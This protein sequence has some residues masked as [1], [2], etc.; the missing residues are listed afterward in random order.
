MVRI[1]VNGFGDIA[2][3]LIG[4]GEDDAEI[5]ITHINT[6]K[7]V[8]QI[9]DLLQEA[10]P[11]GVPLQ[12]DSVSNRLLLRGKEIL[13]TCQPQPVLIPWGETSVT[14][15]VD[16]GE[17]GTSRS[18]LQSHLRES[19]RS[20]ILAGAPSDSSIGRLVGMGLNEMEILPEDDILVLASPC[21]QA[22]ALILKVLHDEFGVVRALLNAGDTSIRCGQTEGIS[23]E[24]SHDIRA[25]HQL[26]P[27]MRNCFDGNVLNLAPTSAPI[28]SLVAELHFSSTAHEVRE[29]F[30][31]YAEGP[32]LHL[33]HYK[34]ETSYQQLTDEEIPALIFEAAATKVIEGHL[35]QVTGWHSGT[36]GHAARII[37]LIKH[38]SQI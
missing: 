30:R 7:S 23:E 16:L 6:D 38:T 3:M 32:L 34:Q 37:D 35:V 33:I 31:R 27:E 28:V 5:A 20:V 22:A 21:A 2:K 9:A 4:L 19:V 17:M 8:Q 24:S 25:I 13:I 26:I 29:A 10:I 1:G 11:S 15:V 14:H 36:R 12:I 18:I